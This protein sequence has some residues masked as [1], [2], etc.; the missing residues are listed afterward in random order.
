MIHFQYAV[1]IATANDPYKKALS[2]IRKNMPKDDSG[3]VRSYKY[4]TIVGYKF[5]KMTI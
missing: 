1:N 4:R 3:E 5:K 2:I